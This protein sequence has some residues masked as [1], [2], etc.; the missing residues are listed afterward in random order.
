MSHAVVAVV[1]SDAG[2]RS[3]PAAGDLVARARRGD[4]GALAT[5][6]QQHAVVLTAAA[7]RVLGSRTEAEDVVQDLFVALPE[8]LARYREQGQFGAWLRRVA[9]R[10]AL[11]RMRSRQRRRESPLEA[12]A[13]LVDPRGRPADVVLERLALERAIAAL[14]ASL[15]VVFVLREVEGYTHSEIAALLG[16]T[17][18]SSEVRLFRAVRRL[19]GSLGA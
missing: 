3:A 12:T 13:D 4:V 15:R 17:R 16:I 9:V 5:L 19:R 18:A 2:E 11:G 7:A 10:L 8:A 14:P 6:Y 1:K